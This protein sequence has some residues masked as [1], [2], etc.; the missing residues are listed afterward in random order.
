[1]T[2]HEITIE[3]TQRCPNR[4][5]Y[6]SSLSDVTKTQCL[7][8][9]IIC[10][11]VD[12]A[13]SLGA[14]SVSLSGG[15]PLL[16]PDIVKIAEYIHAQDINCLLYTSGIVLSEDEQPMSVPS[17]VFE[18]IKGKISKIIV[19]IEAADDITY[20]HIMG[21][22]FGGF[23]L[24]QD[25]VKKAINV[26]I[27]VEAHVVPMKLNLQQLPQI[28]ALCNELGICRVSFLRLVVQGRAYEHKSD[29]LLSEDDVVFAKYLI[30]TQAPQYR[31]SIR[32]GIPF[33]D[34]SH[35]INCLTGT[36]KLDIRYD[37]KVFP[38]EAYKDMPDGINTPDNIHERSLSDIYENS[39]FLNEIRKQLDEFQ[40]ISTCE[41]CMNQYY[42]EQNERR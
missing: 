6:C 41:R 28:M 15:E 25:S 2:L 10:R 32:F 8:Y 27:A 37:G 33:G 35:R 39:S 7:D 31:G 1:M 18:K 34:C 3:V 19:N 4:C 14:K 40:Q 42:R 29:I 26:G 16:H 23:S 30:A 5:I 22:S 24:M 21:T 36:S 9:D 11:V 20:D 38:C 17:E 13:K 12:D